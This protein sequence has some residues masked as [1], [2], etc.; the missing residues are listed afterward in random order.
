MD[1]KTKL[2]MLLISVFLYTCATTPAVEKEP[3]TGL[4][5]VTI[6][7]TLPESDSVNPTAVVLRNNECSTLTNWVHLTSQNVFTEI[8]A[9]VYSLINFGTSHVYNDN[10]IV[11]RE[12]VVH[13][14]VLSAENNDFRLITF[15][16]NSIENV[17]NERANL[18]IYIKQNEEHATILSSHGLR[19]NDPTVRWSG[20]GRISE[21]YIIRRRYVPF[22]IYTLYIEGF[23]IHENL[24]VNTMESTHTVFF[25]SENL[26]REFA[27][28]TINLNASQSNCII[29]ITSFFL[30]CIK[31]SRVI[32]YSS[33]KSN[34]I[35]FRHVPFGKH[36][37]FIDTQLLLSGIYV[38][39][40]VSTHNLYLDS[41]IFQYYTISIQNKLLYDIHGV[42]LHNLTTS[43]RQGTFSP[44]DLMINQSIKKEKNHNITLLGVRSPIHISLNRYEE[45][46]TAYNVD[47][48]NHITVNFT[49]DD[50][51][52]KE[53]RHPAQLSD[54]NR[55]QVQVDI[56]RD[57]FIMRALREVCNFIIEINEETTER[58]NISH[59]RGY[60]NFQPG[61]YYK[62]NLISHCC[63]DSINES[64]TLTILDICIDW[65]EY[66]VK[67][68]NKLSWK[69][70]Q[71][72]S[73]NN[74]FIEFTIDTRVGI[75]QHREILHLNQGYVIFPVNFDF[76]S[77]FDP[78]LRLE[79]TSFTKSD[80]VLIMSQRIIAASYKDGRLIRVSGNFG[81]RWEKKKK[82]ISKEDSCHTS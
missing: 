12:D 24:V 23:V 37:L 21:N 17:S 48:H 59:F 70:C 63:R 4:A 64:L 9:G 77:P 73:R 14:I 34:Q 44:R 19:N 66:I 61:T 54:T 80:T 56:Y 52:T 32:S 35:K 55:F 62:I 43:L 3:F 2:I 6:N 7:V 69:I 72:H 28:V 68:R 18:T 8:A 10:I 47:F 36:S 65:P 26:L 45:Q 53:I 1:R 60:F 31:C 50:K 11:D 67:G 82:I 46:Y 27:H 74:S 22:G 78:L 33:L 49:E 81:G 42:V 58:D 25:D 51:V 13:D 5:T 41:S 29:S 16:N 71:N 75:V 76:S 15:V 40:Q 57:F 38:D 30:G 79:I 39:E 20:G